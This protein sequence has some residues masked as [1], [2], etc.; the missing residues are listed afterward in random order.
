MQ[1]A[2]ILARAAITS[3]GRAFI[4]RGIAQLIRVQHSVQ[5]FLNRIPDT[6]VQVVTHTIV[7]NPNDIPKVRRGPLVRE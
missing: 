2:L 7:I 6:F 5:R 4:A 1:L 3:R